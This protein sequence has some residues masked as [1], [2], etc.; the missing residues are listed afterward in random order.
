MTY[1]EGLA[2]RIRARLAALEGVAEFDEKQMFGGLSFLVD[3]HMAVGVIKGE[4]I[5]RVGPEHAE[6]LLARPEARP[7]DFTG[8]PMRG[9]L[10]IGGAP[11]AEDPVLDHW[12]TAALDFTGTLPAK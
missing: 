8:H 10:T 11:L 1:D 5:V 7:M 12:I 3:G 9:W 2:R 6:E 4:L